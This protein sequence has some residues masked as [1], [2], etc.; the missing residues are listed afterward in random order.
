MNLKSSLFIVI[1]FFLIA[2]STKPVEVEY[3]TTDN[4]VLKADLYLPE[5]VKADVPLV[6]VIHGGGW[7]NRSGDMENICLKLR[8]KGFAAINITYRFA[9]GHHHPV[10]IND[11]KAVVPWIQANTEKYHFDQKQISIWGYS[12]GAHL[13][14]LLANQK[15]INLKIK[16]VVVGGIPSYFPAYPN[17]PLITDLMGMK[18]YDDPKAWQAA[19]PTEFVTKESPPTFIYHGED[20]SLVGYDQAELLAAKLEQVKVKH[21]LEKV[22]NRGHVSTY[23]F[24]GDAEDKAIKFINSTSP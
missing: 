9:P 15:D 19:S 7:S 24:G 23:F 8:N 3:T 14:F 6:I 10:Q 4:Y 11:V 2:C 20:D 22:H 16:A 5:A 13:A 12:A 1:S 21:E 18:F 17:S